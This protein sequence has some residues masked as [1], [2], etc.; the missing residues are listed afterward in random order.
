[1]SFLDDAGEQVGQP[2][3]MDPLPRQVVELQPGGSAFAL[4]RV[5]NA[6]TYDAGACRQRHAVTVR[7]YP[8]GDR[9]PPTAAFSEDV[10]TGSVRQA[11]VA[12]VRPGSGPDPG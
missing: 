8:P 9:V 3:D 10:C 11:G 1:M 12:P 7:V 6:G 2:A 5:S 4:L